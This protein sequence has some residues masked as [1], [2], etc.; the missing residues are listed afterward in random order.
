MEGGISLIGRII[1]TKVPSLLLQ[2]IG[3]SETKWK[4]KCTTLNIRYSYY[5]Q[6][7]LKVASELYII[8]FIIMYIMLKL[9][10]FILF[11]SDNFKISL[12]LEVYDIVVTG[13]IY[14][15]YFLIQDWHKSM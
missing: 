1:Y 15:Y 4:K 6:P 10:E 5:L 8:F 9:P 14:H 11:S 12:L 13:T 2:S 7:T 3:T